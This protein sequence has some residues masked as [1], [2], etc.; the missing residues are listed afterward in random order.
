[1]SMDGGLDVNEDLGSEATPICEY[2]D[3]LFRIGVT[4]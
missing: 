2:S 1:M 3:T 4:P